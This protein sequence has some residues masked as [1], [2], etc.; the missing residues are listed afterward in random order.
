MILSAQKTNLSFVHLIY[1]G[2]L[3]TCVST[4]AVKDTKMSIAYCPARIARLPTGV[5]A[6]PGYA[7]TIRP[8][9]TTCPAGPVGPAGA[10]GALWFTG[11]GAPLPTIGSAGDLYLDVATGDVYQR[12]GDVWV[13]VGNIQGP[14]GEPGDPG[15]P[16]PP[17]EA[18]QNFTIAS[19]AQMTSAVTLGPLATVGTFVNLNDSISAIDIATLPLIPLGDITVLPRI[20]NMTTDGT[21]ASLIGNLVITAF[22]TLNATST[23]EIYTLYAP[24]D[25]PPAN[26]DFALVAG[27]P[28]SVLLPPVIAVGTVVDFA[29]PIAH[30]FDIGGKY[31]FFFQLGNTGADVTASLTGFVSATARI[32]DLS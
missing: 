16:G 28:S 3:S 23:L 2:I 10:P 9:C 6:I 11:E 22:L 1:F 24:P 27:S 30:D 17:G 15:P 25:D 32:T 4:Y 18:L 21:L 7:I 8:Q 19:G 26:L 29:V 31:L 5:S 20:F 13:F 12:F 14:P